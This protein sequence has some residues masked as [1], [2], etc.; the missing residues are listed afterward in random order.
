MHMGRVWRFYWMVPYPNTRMLWPNFRSPLMWDLLAITTYLL[1]STMYLFLPLIPD[2]AMARDRSK[3]W[4]KKFYRILALGFRGTE[5]EWANLHAALNIFAFAI[6]PV[7]FSVHTI[8]SWDFAVAT[9]PGW[10][11]TIFGPYFVIGALHSGIAAVA[12]VLIIVRST[13]KNMK[14]FIRK[15]HFDALGKL[16]LIVSMGWAYFFFNDFMVQWY[17]GDEWT[18]LLLHWHEAGPAGWMW[19][20]MLIFN[21]AIPWVILWN[22][23]WRTNPLVLFIVGLLINVG[24]YFERYII[25]PISLTINRSPFTWFEY[26]PGVEIYLT[27][28][29]F[30]FFI[31]LYMIAS[32]LIPLVPV[33]EVQEGQ[34]SHSIRKI[35]K[36]ELPSVSDLE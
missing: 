30:A 3:G 9:R 11:S 6:L 21:I 18:H 1:A 5:N 17:G 23:R 4:R 25:V 28:G 19:F 33:W 32:K 20:A 10:N 26:K 22:K 2:L 27:I 35:G 36:A 14:Y 34:L 8:V 15:E 29:T 16:M 12:M 7:M 24:M 31:L 13:M